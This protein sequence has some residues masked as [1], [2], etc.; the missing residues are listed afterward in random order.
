MTVK[1]LNRRSNHSHSLAILL[2]AT[3]GHMISSLIGWNGGTMAKT[4]QNNGARYTAE[5]WRRHG[6]TVSETRRIGVGD[7]AERCR[8]LGGTVSETRRNGAGDTVE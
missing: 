8:R 2:L 5:S 7:S 1:I 6:G 4:R 3:Q